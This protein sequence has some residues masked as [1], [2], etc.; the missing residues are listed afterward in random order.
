MKRH[1][2]THSVGQLPA[3]DDDDTG[4][5]AITKGQHEAMPDPAQAPKRAPKI[6]AA[7]RFLAVC[8][9]CGPASWTAFGVCERC[10][11]YE[12]W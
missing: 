2:R 6:T 3:T 8:E 9:W 7:P 1:E 4:E 5:H 12:T 10:G 11:W